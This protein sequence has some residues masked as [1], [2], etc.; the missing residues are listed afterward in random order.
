MA[1]IVAFEKILTLRSTEKDLAL[2]EYQSSVDHFESVATELYNLLKEKEDLEGT[3]HNQIQSSITIHEIHSYQY[4]INL[5]SEQI[6][7]IQGIVQQ[8]RSKME[9]KHEHLSDSYVEMKKFEKLVEIK[10][11]NE[12]ERIKKAENEFLDEVSVQQFL[13]NRKR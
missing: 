11:H 6:S 10:K 3:L 12:A 13:R 5:L 9:T 4:Y 7:R 2:K 1:N 8:A